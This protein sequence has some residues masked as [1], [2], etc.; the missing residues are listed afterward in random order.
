MIFDTNLRNKLLGFFPGIKTRFPFQ[1]FQTNF[2]V[3]VGPGISC[4]RLHDFS[5][6]LELTMDCGSWDLFFSDL[7]VTMT[8]N[9]QL[10]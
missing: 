6:L 9:S 2:N 5:C 4:S 3:E 10:V 7:W 1:E 8:E